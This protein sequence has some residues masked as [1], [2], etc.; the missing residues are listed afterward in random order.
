MPRKT[1]SKVPDHLTPIRPTTWAAVYRVWYQQEGRRADW[2]RHL[3][4]RGF[5]SWR[6]WRQAVVIK[7]FG[8]TKKRWQLYR[9]DEPAAV[10]DWHGGPFPGWK[11]T[12]Y[13]GTQTRSFRWLVWNGKVLRNKKVSRIKKIPKTMTLF[14][15]AHKNRVVIIDG[16]HRCSAIAIR[17]AAGQSVKTKIM[18]ALAPI[19]KLPKLKSGMV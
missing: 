1:R 9:V 2:R 18:I 4:T 15:L 14:G 17:L 10:L 3:Q 5:P 12:Y 7:P 8:L 13:H 16:M 6:S 19:A 11:K